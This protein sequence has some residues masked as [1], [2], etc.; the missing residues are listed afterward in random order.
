MTT[1]SLRPY[2]IEAIERAR[3][4][5]RGGSKNVLIC[6]PTGSGKTLLAS[7]LID[8]S[9]RKGRRSAFV[10]DRLSLI[11]QT[12]ETFGRY[13]I[14]HGVIQSSHP[15]FYPSRPV[16]IC[17]IQTVARRRW[18]DADL[19]VVDECHTM[20]KAVKA[21]ITPRDTVAIGLTATPFSKGLGK[22]YDAVVN[23][24]TTNALIAD[25]WLSKYRIFSC[26]EPDMTG[27]RV[28]AGEWDEKETSKRA[29]QVV[30]DVVAEYMQHGDGRK[31]ICSAV[32]TDHV[33]ELQRQFLAAG[34]TAA[35]YTYKDRD[36]DRADTLAD[37]RR[38]ESSIRGLITV[39]AASKG[40]DC[41]DIGCVIMARP[42]RKS[43]TEHIQ[44]FGRGLRIA[45][46]KQDCVILCHSG[47]CARFF[48]DTNDFFEHGVTE[49]DDGTKPDKA[50][51]EKKAEKEPVKCPACRALHAPMPY[52][53]VC[54]HQYPRKPTVEHVPG[55]LK[56]M[57]ATGN[58]TL[59][60]R[61]LWPQVV[62]YALERRQGDDARRMAQAIYRTITGEFAYARIETTTPIPCSDEVRRRIRA[63][64]IRRAYGQQ[65]ASA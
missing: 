55:S 8:E 41:P 21:R 38:S 61:E 14:D 22:L 13:G 53:P 2:Q 16:Q 44:F 15:R 47:N 63:A 51:P 6:A 20:T 58:Q 10:V 39:T 27:V 33:A 32:N 50:K 29:L 17:S 42:L 5:I 60:K 23:V 12:S 62:A 25:G 24:T 37:Y 56:E 4:A 59:L 45:P 35:T 46:G 36:E 54:G 48:A 31:F 57:L 40:F 65:R 26:A 19:L 49:L 34:I 30:G 7:H 52:C 11:E 28:V 1:L 18:P 43:L 64:Q 9:R 3:E